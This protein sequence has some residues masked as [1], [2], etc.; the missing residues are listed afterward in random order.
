MLEELEC[1]TFRDYFDRGLQSPELCQLVEAF[2]SGM[3]DIEAKRNTQR[4]SFLT[5]NGRLIQELKNKCCGSF[6][7]EEFLNVVLGRYQFKVASNILNKQKQLF[8][9]TQKEMEYDPRKP[10]APFTLEKLFRDKE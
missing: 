5:I 9:L 4:Q 2:L 6:L 10:Q 1:M 8:E 3:H 7:T